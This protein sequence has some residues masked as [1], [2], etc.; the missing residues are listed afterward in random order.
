MDVGRKRQ[1]RADLEQQLEKYRREL[2][3]ARKHLAESLEQQTAT[4]EVLQVISSSSGELEPV[5]QAVLANA[6]R[7][8][9]AKF[10][11][12]NLYDGEVYRAVALHNVPPEYAE[13]RRGTVIRVDPR[14]ILAQV[15]RTRD[16]VHTDDLRTGY[17]TAPAS[18]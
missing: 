16:V 13:T 14:G 7:L 8:C 18:R 1:P 15:A 17:R 3:E 12:L 9:D 2:A 6:V 5:F 4:S 10:G 11:M